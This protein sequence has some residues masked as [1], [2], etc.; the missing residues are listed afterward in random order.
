MEYKPRQKSYLNIKEAA[1]QYEVSRAKLH[2]MIR[3]GRLAAIKDSHDE[4]ATL[5]KIDDLDEMFRL[6]AEGTMYREIS[7]VVNA[8]VGVLTAER[9]ARMDELRDRIARRVGLVEDS[10]EVLRREREHRGAELTEA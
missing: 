7:S 8:S 6:P 4:R 1:A 9:A 3:D 2:R 10:V 5:V